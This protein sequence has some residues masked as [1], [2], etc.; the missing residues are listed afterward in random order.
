MQSCGVLVRDR[1]ADPGCDGWVRITIGDRAQM[2]RA[3]HA[4]TEGLREI[5]WRG[6][7]Q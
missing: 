1:S 3:I 5:E 4:M 6:D 7:A 2:Q